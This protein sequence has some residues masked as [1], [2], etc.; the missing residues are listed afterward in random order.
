[1]ATGGRRRSAGPAAG[2]AGAWEVVERG[3]AAALAVMEPGTYLVIS[4]EDTPEGAGYYVQF[5][6]STDELHAEAVSNAYLAPER[7]IPPE[8]VAELGRLGW[9][10]PDAETRN[11]RRR[12]SLP[13]P[14]GEIAALAV[15]TLR[16]AFGLAD[17]A[18]LRYRY[19]RFAGGDLE[20]PELG[21]D[22]VVPQWPDASDPAA[23]AA[24]I[25][26]LRGRVE[27]AVAKALN[28][29]AVHVDADG[30]IPVRAGSAVV[31]VRVLGGLPPAIRLFA[32]VL[33][34]V[35]RTADLLL[36]LNRVNAQ[37]RYGRVFLDQATVVAAMEL[38][39]VD[40]TDEL[41]AFALVE[42]G[43]LADGLDDTLRGRFGGLPAFDEAPPLPN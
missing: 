10:G 34:N 41:V 39:S 12:W 30:D 6:R 9:A 35:A 14:A 13:L 19:A 18:A 27:A 3:I 42:L 7:R 43:N 15:R 33:R 28:Q 40:L 22:R 5:A 26:D 16:T 38:P 21:L 23:H 20:L 11:H 31:F 17:P 36:E 32:P 4:T 37:I 8:R 25:D 29:G 1:M 2:R 24:R